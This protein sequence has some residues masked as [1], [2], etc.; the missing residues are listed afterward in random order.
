[1]KKFSAC[2]LSALF[3]LALL[4]PVWGCTKA[5]EPTLVLFLGDSIAEGVAGPT[6]VVERESYAYYGIIGNINGYEYYN[7]GV[8]GATTKTLAAYV[9]KEDDGINM[10]ESLITTAD[11]IHIS[12]IGNDLLNTNRDQM[13]IN[14][15]NGNFDY[16]LSKKATAK[17][18]ITKIIQR[19][20]TLNPDVT[21]ILQ[22]LY[23]P[24]A[25]KSPLVTAYA[26]S[27]L[28][29]MGYSEADYHGLMAELITMM[30]DVFH[31][32]LAENTVTAKDGTVTAPFELIDVYSAIERVYQTDK[33]RYDT[34]FCED[35][36]H[37]FNEGHAIMAELLQAKLTELGL[38]GANTLEK[39]KDIRRAQVARLYAE[40]ADVAA[41]QSAINAATDMSA[42]TKAYFDGTKQFVPHTALTLNYEGEHFKQDKRFTL[43]ALSVMKYDVFALIDT[44]KS[45]VLFKADG[46]YEAR[47]VPNDYAMLSLKLAA[48]QA[49]TINLTDEPY[50]LRLVDPYIL[51]VVPEA[52]PRDIPSILEGAASLYGVTVDGLNFETDSAQKLLSTYKNTGKLIVEKTDFITQDFALTMR[53]QYRLQE[54]MSRLTGETF[55]A[56]YV[57][58]GIDKTES[59]MRYTY[60]Q[61][62]TSESI[63]LVVDVAEAVVEGKKKK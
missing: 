4:L 37:P 49:G 63:R 17:A 12:I 20:R 43:T 55:T 29:S 36:I 35:G 18:N 7:R 53:G 27:V 11:V 21:L 40:T 56:I 28:A 41:V 44:E 61:N 14:A 26:R 50:R 54:V 58:A 6:P 10:V 23:N 15:A 51:N 30:N 19:I 62:D 60:R 24:V 47:V 57:N 39:Y 45:Y 9:Q 1:M 8:S 5:E 25:E 46:S 52:D 34:L 32:Y 33:A 13:L 59:Y 38:Q 48:S 42:L 2:I 31:E 3:L 22:T 16:V